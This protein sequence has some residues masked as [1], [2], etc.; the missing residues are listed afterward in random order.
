MMNRARLNKEKEAK[1]D[2]E[3]PA[4]PKQKSIST[5]F[6]PKADNTGQIKEPEVPSPS[7][8]S[9]LRPCEKTIQILSSF[10]AVRDPDKA[11]SGGP[12]VS[13]LGCQLTF[14]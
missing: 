7:R 14:R 10:S 1:K 13:Q 12:E 2:E 11:N 9:E 3:I 5:Y 8:S 6:L 4:K